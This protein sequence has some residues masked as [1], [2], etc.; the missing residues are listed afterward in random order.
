MQLYKAVGL[1][2]AKAL[3]TLSP[4]WSASPVRQPWPLEPIQAG[5]PSRSLPR[6]KGPCGAADLSPGAPGFLFLLRHQGC[7]GLLQ[8]VSREDQLQASTVRS[9]LTQGALVS[10]QGAPSCT[11]RLRVLLRW[12]K[13][14]SAASQVL[15]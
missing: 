9:G 8:A 3:G 7:L 5:Q 15:T 11:L 1:A 4:D 6:L 10:R 2:Q 13:L 14:V 12:Q